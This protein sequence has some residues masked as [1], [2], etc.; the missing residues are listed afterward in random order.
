LFGSLCSKNGHVAGFTVAAAA[1]ESQEQLIAVA[2]TQAVA[3]GKQEKIDV[4]YRPSFGAHFAAGS[5][6]WPAT[7]ATNIACDLGECMC[8][9]PIACSARINSTGIGPLGKL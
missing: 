2:S 7:P 8:R 6:R 5:R 4:L 1:P 3:G 9:Q